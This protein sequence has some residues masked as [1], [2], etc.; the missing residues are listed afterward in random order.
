MICCEQCGQP[1]PLTGIPFRCSCGGVFD[2]TAPPEV[3][4]DKIEPGLPGMWRYRH[5]FDLPQNAPVVTLG[6]GSTP[7]I[8]VETINGPVWLKLESLNPT[9]SYK[10]RGSAVLASQLLARG[11]QTAVE[12][13]SGNAG[14]SFAAYAARCGIRASIYVPETASGPKRRQIEEYG[15]RLVAVP[16]ARSAAA[17]AVLIEAENGVPYASHAYLPFGLAGI[18]SIAYELVEKQPEIGTVMMP[19]GH[20]GLMLG[21]V[22]GFKA[23]LAAGWIQRLPYF[24]GVQAAGCAPLVNRFHQLHGVQTRYADGDTLAEGVR[25]KQ[26]VRGPALLREISAQAGEFIAIPEDQLLPAYT[27]LSRQGVYVEPTSALA[28]AAYENLAEKLPRPITLILTGSGL[29]YN[30]VIT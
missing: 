5:A 6:E 22:R 23:M 2:F 3:N 15:A 4:R 24:V 1:Y 12:D 26:P 18:A 9:G 29:K 16:G 25:V 14:A 19:V 7:L 20:G 13:S 10:D 30:P 27:M 21:V 17:A 8:E 28:W 11:A